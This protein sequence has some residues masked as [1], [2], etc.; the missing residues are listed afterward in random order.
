MHFGRWVV[1]NQTGVKDLAIDDCDAKQTV[2]IF[3][4]K[5]SVLQIK[6]FAILFI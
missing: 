3:N 2:Y 5:D 4:C 6:G 1:E